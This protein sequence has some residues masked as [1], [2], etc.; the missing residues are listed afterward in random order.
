MRVKVPA[1]EDHNKK[2]VARKPL[3]F[4]RYR[5]MLFNEKQFLC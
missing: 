3:S 4:D 1:L 2:R 5:N